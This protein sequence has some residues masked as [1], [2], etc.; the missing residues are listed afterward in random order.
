MNIPKLTA[1]LIQ[2]EGRRLKPYRDSV[3]KLT[4]GVGRNLDDVGISDTECWTML[5]N[6]I[7]RVSATLDAKLPWWRQLDDDRQNVLANMT[8]NMGIGGLLG[9]A[10][11]LVAL[12]AG[13]YEEASKQMLDSE[14]A[15]QVGDRAIRL[16]VV[17]RGE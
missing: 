9:F 11:F 6:D 1:D 13:D 12:K 2:D 3:G 4:I 5:T 17:I 7:A 8:F 10:H 16:A 15:R 14:W